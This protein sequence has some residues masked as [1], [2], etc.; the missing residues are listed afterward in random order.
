MNRYFA[1]TVCSALVYPFLLSAQ[2][3][4]IPRIEAMPALTQPVVLRDWKQVARNYD[5]LVYDL[6]AQG[7]YLP[8]VHLSTAPGTNY[9]DISQFY[10]DT[11]V[12]SRSAG[13]QAEAI[14]ILPSLVGATLM[15]IDKRD[16]G[17]V[18][19]V[20]MSRNFF[21]LKNGQNVYLN[22]YSATSGGDWWYDL[23][24]NVYFY[25]L[26]TLY[27]PD[28][29]PQWRGQFESVASRWYE[30]VVSLGGDS[31]TW[32]LPSINYRAFNLITGKPL[33]TGVPEPESAG[34]MAWLLYKAYL[35]TGELRYMQGA[36]LC[37]EALC[38]YPD[39][40]SYELQLAYGVQVAACMNTREECDFYLDRLLNWCFNRGALR[41]WG[42][43]SGRWGDYDVSG[44]IG[45]ANDAGNDYAFVMNGFQQAAALAPV[46]KYDKRYARAIGK[47]M[48]NLS[49]ASR[50]FYHNALPEELQEPAGAAWLGVYDLNACM[51]FESMKQR[52]EGKTPYAMGDAVRGGWA[53]TDVSLYSG[54]SVG[55]LA[56]VVDNTDVEGM[57]RVDVNATDFFSDEHVPAYL[58]YNPYESSRIVTLPLPHGNYDLYDSLSDEYVARNVSGSSLIEISGDAARLIALVPA[59][60]SLKRNGTVLY[61]GDK[62]VD[63]H[64]DYD[65]TRTMRVNALEVDRAVAVA[66]ELVT[67]RLHVRNIPSG[68][69]VVCEWSVNGQVIEDTN[70][71]PTLH[72]V[73]PAGEGL[74][75]IAVTARSR[76]QEVVDSVSVEVVSERYEAPSI[77]SLSTDVDM[78]VE[79]GASI[80][81]M[82]V[83]SEIRDDLQCVWSVTGGDLLTDSGV[84]VLWRLPE[85]DGL[86]TITCTAVNRFGKDVRT[87]DVLV[88]SKERTWALPVIYYP[89]NGNTLNAVSSM[90]NADRIGG[91]FVADSR[92]IPD[93][94]F[95]F[96]TVSDK[97]YTPGTERLCFSEAVSL[98]C[99]F[100]AD[101]VLQREQFLIS[102]G[103]WEER[104][105]LSLTPDMKL[106]WTVNT[107][108]GVVDVDSKFAVEK[109]RFYH[110]VA[111]YTGY[112]LEL[113]IDGA[114]DNFAAQSGAIRSTAYEISYGAKDIGNEEYSFIGA[115]DEIRIY[116]TA[117]SLGDAEALLHEWSL[118]AVKLPVV[119][120]L[121][122][123]L[124]GDMLHIS[125]PQG[126]VPVSV[127]QHAA[128][129]VQYPAYIVSAQESRVTVYV[130]NVPRGVYLIT[131]ADASGNG[132]ML[133]VIR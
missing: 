47:W 96:E 57:I 102:H 24:P 112:S 118:S 106:R 63:Y 18:D 51:P 12:G 16:V 97:L 56:A 127:K 44:L 91:R 126:A 58:Y 124:Q 13:H 110:V 52:Y 2:Q 37:L 31:Y 54:S 113:Y 41:G 122:W 101:D 76:G 33:T 82:A 30:A 64:Y 9:S 35:E 68:S 40:P 42:V 100:R 36:Q 105:K 108:D 62:V 29:Y 26:Y 78:P 49:Q 114:F 117:L 107:M 45:E 125:L 39:N 20:G 119:N 50:L 70:G 72:W 121:S 17:G 15:G 99:W 4:D 79:T 65:Y 120:R 130:G 129:G 8:L 109:G 34:T 88:R 83:V 43:I 69:S 111:L 67:A 133:R 60:V 14:N 90:Y 85:E 53:A 73:A 5:A 94:A 103:S 104:Y 74:Y 22:G 132:Y 48:L 115:M 81:V 7:E 59:G 11:Y 75:T 6:N 38:Q 3:I 92:G 19:Y 87:L 77:V 128:D 80:N 71:A 10:L 98:S 86:Y 27:T 46:A 21:N 23:M 32:S 123:F 61:A 66:G 89:L 116:D 28:A 95:D 55:Y 84:S 25:Q 1:I 131:L 93:S